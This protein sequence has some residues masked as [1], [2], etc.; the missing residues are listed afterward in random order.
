[1]ARHSAELLNMEREFPIEELFFSTTN[2]SGVIVHGNQLFCSVSGYEEAELLGA[3]HSIIRHPD[4]PRSVF[5]L[6]WET[7]AAKKTIA[8][9]VKNLAKDQRYYWVLAV[10]MP[11]EVGYLSIRLKPTSA[12]FPVV[13]QLYARL[14]QLE[15]SI[16]VE[17]KRR[18]AAIQAGRAELADQLSRLGYASYEAFMLEA[19]STEMASRHAKMPTQRWERWPCQSTLMHQLYGHCAAIDHGI[20]DAFQR[21]E[22]FKSTNMVLLQRSSSILSLAEQIRTLS[23][24]ASIAASQMGNRGTTLRVVSESLGA[25]SCDSQELTKAVAQRVQSV[26]VGLDHLIFDLAATKLQ[27]EVALQFARE[28]LIGHQGQCTRETKQS[29]DILF[30]EMRQR[31]GMVYEHVKRAEQNF[32]ELR[33]QIGRLARNNQTLRFVQFAGMKECVGGAEC[34]SFSEVFSQVRSQID[35]TKSSCDQLAESISNSFDDVSALLASRV[36]LQPH[37]EALSD[38]QHSGLS[39]MEMI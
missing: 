5:H 29:L 24:N 7:I 30:G 34:A 6:L 19:L 15:R 20:Q 21:I 35:R 1:M 17:P 2:A 16:E 8:A 27:S 18:T 32:A 31:I 12:L 9:Y 4:M 37:L 22:E 25:V 36:R 11:C 23:L 26:V 13:Q 3:A 33:T 28:I 39:A 38:F 14:L 10:V